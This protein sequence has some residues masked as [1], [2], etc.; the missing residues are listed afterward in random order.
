MKKSHAN[1]VKSAKGV[2]WL[3]LYA[4]ALIIL[5]KDIDEEI[6][7]AVNKNFYDWL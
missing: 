1:W 3:Q 6:Q 4:E 7:Q 2:G 5:Q